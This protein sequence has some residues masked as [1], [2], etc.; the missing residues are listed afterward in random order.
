MAAKWREVVGAVAPTLGKLLGGPLGG[1]AGTLAAKILTGK[2]DA[3]DA[4]LDAAAAKLTPD[5]V[6]ALRLAA[7][8]TT[9]HLSD[10]G[11]KIEELSVQLQGVD[12]GDRA[13]AR[14]REIALKDGAPLLIGITVLCIWGY[15]TYLAVTTGLAPTLDP[16][17][18][19]RILGTLDAAV[20]G[21]VWYF[22]GSSRGSDKKTDAL[23]AK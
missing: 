15:V 11:I 14:A 21:V 19:G 23:T 18:A 4:E 1:M 9:R 10:N 2:D 17:I 7:E 12:A 16:G 20:M 5:Q 22:L 3:T 8:E 6:V 13:N